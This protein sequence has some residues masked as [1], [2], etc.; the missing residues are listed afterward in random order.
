M[1]K[2]LVIACILGI[3]AMG[4]A[5]AAAGSWGLNFAAF[6]GTTAPANGL[7][8]FGIGLAAQ[9]G[10]P[11]WLGV[12]AEMAG[13]EMTASGLRVDT[14]FAIAGMSGSDPIQSD[15]RAA[16]VVGQ[17]WH[18]SVFSTGVVGNNLFVRT[19]ALLGGDESPAA[20]FTYMLYQDGTSNSW[21]LSSAIGAVPET[22]IGSVIELAKVAQA[23]AYSF[24]FRQEHV[25]PE[26][27]SILALGSGLV[28]LVG[29]VTRR[30]RA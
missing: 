3:M 12:N 26:P 30:R 28:G 23:N 8:V 21:D 24:T 7:D 18:F 6:N 14:A 29:L 9:S 15:I 10:G 17:E 27:S 5:M 20:G 4:S 19:G 22:N 1:K 25:V 11:L 16:D 13:Y 2:F